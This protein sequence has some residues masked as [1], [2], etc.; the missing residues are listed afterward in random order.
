MLISPNCKIPLTC[1]L[2]MLRHLSGPG[3]LYTFPALLDFQ[4]LLISNKHTFIFQVQG[5]LSFTPRKCYGTSTFIC[6]LMLVLMLFQGHLPPV[7]ATPINH[8]DILTYFVPF[9]PIL[10]NIIFK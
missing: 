7:S 10:F 4:F 3:P 1:D 9:K 2:E 6:N 8:A 5:Y